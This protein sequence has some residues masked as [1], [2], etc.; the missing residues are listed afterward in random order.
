[1]LDVLRKLVRGNLCGECAR[2]CVRVRGHVP[3]YV[4]ARAF[5]YRIYIY[6][7]IYMCVCMCVYNSVYIYIYIYIHL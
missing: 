4:C 5:L 3:I 7:Y 2:V 6:I 1:M